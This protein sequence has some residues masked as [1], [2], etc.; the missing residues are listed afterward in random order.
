MNKAITLLAIF[1]LALGVRAAVIVA[2][3]APESAAG[4]EGNSSQI[5]LDTGGPARFQQVYSSSLFSAF[6]QFVIQ[7]AFRGDA[8]VGRDYATTLTGVEA[9][10]STTSKAVDSLSPVFDL[11]VGPD[12]KIVV[13]GAPIFIGGSGGHGNLEAWSLIFD[14]RSNP[15]PYNPAAGNLLLDIKVFT[16]ASTSPFD[17]VDATGDTVSSV[18]AYGNPMPTSGQTSSLGLATFLGV[19]PVPEPSTVPL[20]FLGLLVLVP[21]VRN[22]IQSNDKTYELTCFTAA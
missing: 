12:D 17:A 21:V 8:F 13:G 19:R 4:R 6:P 14:F 1:L 5:P 20:F 10:L 18:F 11:N 7:I 15:F 3:I 16:G 2:P 22:R 9:H